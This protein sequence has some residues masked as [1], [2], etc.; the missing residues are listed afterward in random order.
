MAGFQPR[1]ILSAIVLGLGALVLVGGLLLAQP[2]TGSPGAIGGPF[3]LIAPDGHKVTQA[4]FAGAPYL[5]FFGY[6]HCPDVCPTTLSD[7]SQIFGKLGKDRKIA[8]AFISVDPER[9]TPEV[10]KDFMASFDPR[11]LALTGTPEALAP[12]FKEFRVYHKKVPGKEGDYS[13]DHTALVYLMDKN[14]QFAS[15]F[16]SSQPPEAAARELARYF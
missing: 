9:D 1:W 2:K 6:A 11:I 3:S 12:V 4:D 16:D 8:A 7:I 5:V 14:G 10:M 13:M 15:S